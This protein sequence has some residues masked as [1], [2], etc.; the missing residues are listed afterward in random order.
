MGIVSN[1]Q[2]KGGTDEEIHSPQGSFIST[3]FGGVEDEKERVAFVQGKRM[4]VCV[5]SLVFES[6]LRVIL[7]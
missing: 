1:L 4:F 6:C 3:V 2:E 7:K 5:D